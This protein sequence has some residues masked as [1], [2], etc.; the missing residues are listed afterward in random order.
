M[1]TNPDHY[2]LSGLQYRKPL[3]VLDRWEIDVEVLTGIMSPEEGAEMPNESFDGHVDSFVVSL[4]SSSGSLLQMQDSE[5]GISLSGASIMFLRGGEKAYV[6]FKSV[7]GMME[8]VG[9]LYFDTVYEN[10]QS[11]S[12]LKKLSCDMN[13][14][15]IQKISLSMRVDTE[16][17]TMNVFYR[18]NKK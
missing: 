17:D 10:A 16:E 7:P 14:S 18:V 12:A 11:E 6:M 1:I 5:G 8:G 3:R 4:S 2:T 9:Q 15:G 13:G